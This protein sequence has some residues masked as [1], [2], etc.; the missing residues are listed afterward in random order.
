[1]KTVRIAAIALLASLSTI[2]TAQAGVRG[3]VVVFYFDDGM[4]KVEKEMEPN[5][6]ACLADDFSYHMGHYVDW[7]KK[8]RFPFSIERSPEFQV[9]VGDIPVSFTR[10]SFNSPLGVIMIRLDGTYEICYGVCRTALD[11]V[12]T[13]GIFFDC[14]MDKENY[15]A[16]PK[17]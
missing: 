3:Y 12:H 11:M 16:D 9:K 2:A 1:M 4:G 17:C 13:T 14:E 10:K 8:Q 6:F 7:L 5:E 15:Y